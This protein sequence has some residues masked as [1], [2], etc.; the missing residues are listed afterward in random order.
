[1]APAGGKRVQVAK[2]KVVARRPAAA[3]AAANVDPATTLRP[4]AIIDE[5]RKVVWPPFDELSRM[6]GIVILTVLIFACILGLADFLL[7]NVVGH[8]Y[9]TQ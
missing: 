5:L 1:M 4:K 9:P 6:T 7:A 3:T 8:I 2:T